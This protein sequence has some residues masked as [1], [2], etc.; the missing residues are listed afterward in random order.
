MNLP[1][2]D[3]AGGG[4]LAADRGLAAARGLAADRPSLSEPWGEVELVVLEEREEE[5]LPR[6]DV[7]WLVELGAD[8]AGYIPPTISSI[9]VL[10][11]LLIPPSSPLSSMWRTI[12]TILA[13][14]CRQIGE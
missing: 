7:L 4:G 9:G 1:A 3:I 12:R 2:G 5:F 11:A 6:L 13:A 10:N 8:P 14:I